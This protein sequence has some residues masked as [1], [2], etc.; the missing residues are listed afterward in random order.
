VSETEVLDAYASE[1]ERFLDVRIQ[2][3]VPLLVGRRVR[4]K[5][6]A[7]HKDLTARASRHYSKP[8]ARESRAVSPESL[9]PRDT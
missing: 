6:L 9:P 1:L 8:A 3:F 2:M 5:L 7:L 4:R